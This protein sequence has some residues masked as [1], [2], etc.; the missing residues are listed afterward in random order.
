MLR[1]KEATLAAII[2][3]IIEEEPE[4]QDDIANKLNVSRRYVA[5]LLKPLMENGAVKHPYVVD[6]EKLSELGIYQDI[7]KFL[8]DVS[9]IFEKMGYNVLQNLDKVFK[10]LENQDLDTAKGIILQDYALNKMED[11]V[12]L[13]LKMNALKYFPTEQAMLISFIASN[14]ERCGDYISN[15]AEEI[16]NG[17][18]IKP[19]IMKDVVEI[20]QI[21]R[22]MFINAMNLLENKKMEFKIYELET[23]LHEKLSEIMEKI[24]KDESR[25]SADI[26]YYI[27]FGMFLKDVERFG[28]RCI[29]IFESA[30]EFHY[31]IPQNKVPE[32]VKNFKI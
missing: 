25:G 8:D 27:Q 12:N 4:T 16:V 1:G 24:S 31:N 9:T 22:E 7:N 14:I 10:A 17:L 23:K 19:S 29:K 30:R 26:N 18:N 11:E 20:Y 3:V 13:V 32:S 15:I 5:K 28:D 21:I 2:K 6:V